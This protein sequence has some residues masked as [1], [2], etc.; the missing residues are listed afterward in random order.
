VGLRQARVR[1]E[2]A[3]W[4]PT[5]PVSIWIPANS[6]ARTVARQLLGERHGS[7]WTLSPRWA[8]GPR[9]LD[10]R[11]FIFRGGEQRTCDARTPPAEVLAQRGPARRRA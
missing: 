3:A 10:D 11:H 8:V 5:I 6:V 9:I 7:C 4:Y 2:Y 1:N